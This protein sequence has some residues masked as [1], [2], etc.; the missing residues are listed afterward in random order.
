MS[1]N[2]AQL[3]R[4]VVAKG[5]QIEPKAFNLLLQMS[6]ETNVGALIEE[7]IKLKGEEGNRTIKA[8]DIQ[9]F[10]T[11]KDTEMK[12]DET[13]LNE[14]L[15]FK[16]LQNY[17]KV[18]AAD[19]VEGFR[20]L[21]LSRYQKLLALAKKRRDSGNIESITRLED[22]KLPMK[23][24]G[25]IY[26]KTIKKGSAT[27]ILEDL[28]NKIEAT[29][30][31]VS[32]IKNIQE[33]P[34][35][36]LVVASITPIRKKI[37]TIDSITLPD[38]PEHVPNLSKKRLYAVLT[39]DLHIGN[40]YFLKQ[41]FKTFIDWL[42]K[43]DNEVALRIRYLLICGDII[44]GVGVYPNQ[45]KELITAD[46][47]QQFNE[48]AALLKNIPQ[49]IQ[50]FISPGNHEPVRQS[51]PQ[52]PIPKEY[53]SS[54]SELSNVVLVSNPVWLELEGVKVLMY[55]GKS[56]EDVVATTPGLK[57]ERPAL[58][59][60]NLLKARH[61][62]PIYGRR[63]P[64][65]PTYEDLLVIDQIPDIFH[66]GHIHILDTE[67]YRGCLLINSGT[68]QSQTSYQ[69]DMGINPTPAI[70]PIVDLSTLQVI[71]LDFTKLQQQ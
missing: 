33:A 20:Q 7:V 45:E 54:L 59:M 9:R 39:S 29:T 25:L 50:I 62:A 22:S 4:E 41:A 55:H 57:V 44:D 27:I 42:N 6:K 69:L 47:K 11:K 68:W 40:K 10:T 21:F 43:K 37:Y 24:A 60:K 8:E 38:I 67:R 14:P 46:V 16:V 71:T 63:T 1:D 61:L 23:V 35:D 17:E 49:N 52:P 51:I 28:T 34:L 66:T 5:Y 31:E 70:L 26:S 2:A 13:E 36:A 56:L 53:A 15:N 30:F 48:V 3:I 32:I 12:I 19:G 18:K 58:A 65:L 64:I